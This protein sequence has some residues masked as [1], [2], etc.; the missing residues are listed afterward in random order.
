MA[1]KDVAAESKTL[2]CCKKVLGEIMLDESA[3]ASDRIAAVK[4]LAELEAGRK[5]GEGGVLS[6]CLK[7]VPPE[8]IN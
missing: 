7:D 1:K 2:K 8:Y 4:L 5:T 3:K 6:V